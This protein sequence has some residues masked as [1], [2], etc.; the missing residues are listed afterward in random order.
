M[1]TEF[2]PNY[3]VEPI[4]H[5]KDMALQ[6]VLGDDLLYDIEKYGIRN[7]DLKPLARLFKVPESFFLNLQK[8]YDKDKKRLN[9]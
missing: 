3:I 1:K 7:I 2:K 5:L 4:E 9:L 6:R 8:N